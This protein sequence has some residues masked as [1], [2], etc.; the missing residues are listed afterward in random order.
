MM[1]PDQGTYDQVKSYVL[2]IT[3]SSVCLNCGRHG[4]IRLPDPDEIWSTDPK[5]QLYL[6]PGTKLE[7]ICCGAASYWARWRER[8]KRR[9]R[10]QARRLRRAKL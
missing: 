8:W 6:P 10:N 4:A 7:V 9:L 5:F 2:K 3:V 1:F